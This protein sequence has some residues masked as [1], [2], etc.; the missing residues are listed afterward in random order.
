M[1]FAFAAA[2]AI[3]LLVVAPIAAHLLRVRRAQDKPFPPAHLVPPSLP[4]SRQRRKLEDRALFGIRLL[5]ILALALLG[6]TPLLT[7]SRLSIFRE[8]GASVAV[9]IVVDD[10]MSMRARDDGTTPRF[11]RAKQEALDLLAGAQK[12]DAIA[13]VLAGDPVRVALAPS[14]DLAV[15]ERMLT[16][17]SVDISRWIALFLL[18]L[19]AAE[20]GVRTLG[21]R[22]QVSK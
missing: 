13:V 16:S 6:A 19:L 7:C 11:T 12:G 10:S 5:A 9:A 14:T 1:T 20:L 15:V 2:L 21:H 3:A 18:A 4:A 8:G 22:P 17:G